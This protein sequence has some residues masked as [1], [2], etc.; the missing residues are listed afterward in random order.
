[1]E[2]AG[3]GISD[4][5]SRARRWHQ[6]LDAVLR[7]AVLRPVTASGSV[8]RPLF[9]CCGRVTHSCASTLSVMDPDV[10]PLP[11]LR[12]RTS[13]LLLR[14][15]TEADLPAVAATLSAD[16]TRNPLLPRFPA[17]D[18][19]TSRAVSAHQSYWQS[20]G[21][22]SLDSWRLDLVVVIGERII[23]VQSLEGEDFL[24]LRTVDS[25]SYLARDTVDGEGQAGAARRPGPRL[26]AARRRLR[27]H[28]GL[29]S[30]RRLAGRQPGTRL[31]AERR[32]P[33]PI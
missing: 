17:L 1:M 27:R 5:Q 18:E 12:L 26:R 24:V 3:C 21:N 22:W 7:G 20:V 2:L 13:D 9:G 25:A 30:Q 6:N 14:P 23:G 15:T 4:P 29:A 28:F 10:W 32:K 11:G 19:G 8:S 16:A 33:P 31:Q